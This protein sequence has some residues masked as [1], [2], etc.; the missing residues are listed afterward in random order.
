M[1]LSLS[2]HNGMHGDNETWCLKTGTVTT[3]DTDMI[4]NMVTKPR[5]PYAKDSQQDFAVWFRRL[6]QGL[7]TNLE[8]WDAEGDGREVQKDGIYVHLWL[9][10][11]EVGQKTQFCKAIILQ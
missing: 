3:T 10:H 11:V 6:K 1:S 2:P 4:E 7:C 5:G 9:I 8:G